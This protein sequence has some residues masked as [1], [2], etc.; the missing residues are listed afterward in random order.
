MSITLKF[1][2]AGTVTVNEFDNYPAMLPVMAYV[3]SK[4]L[5]YYVQDNGKT[6]FSGNLEYLEKEKLAPV[7]YTLKKKP[8]RGDTISMTFTDFVQLS[9][10]A[11]AADRA[12]M[13]WY[14]I[15]NRTKKVIRKGNLDKL[16]D[17]APAP[18]A[19]A[20]P[21]VD[22]EPETQDIDIDI[23]AVIDSMNDL[24]GVDE[25]MS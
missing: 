5:P 9:I 1:M 6:V 13:P 17:K 14:V 22:P 2:H 25:G 15:D 4:N 21:P 23:D 7:S 8:W 10:E 12:G 20:V 19:G 24:I 3:Q 18:K 16:N 11:C